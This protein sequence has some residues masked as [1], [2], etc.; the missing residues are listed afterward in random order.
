[1]SEPELTNE[2]DLETEL[3]QLDPEAPVGIVQHLQMIGSKLVSISNKEPDRGKRSEY[4]RFVGELLEEI[5]DEIQE[6]TRNLEKNDLPEKVAALTAEI[7]ENF[8]GASGKFLDAIEFY[9]DFIETE[10]PEDIEQ[11]TQSITE[12]VVLLEE[13][14]AKARELSSLPSGSIEA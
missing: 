12:G 10:N 4:Y 13:A 7:D 9:Y 8:V 5:S 1:M 11:A 6:M 2:P 3:G 14:D